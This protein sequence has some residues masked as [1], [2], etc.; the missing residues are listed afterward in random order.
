MDCHEEQLISIKNPFKAFKYAHKYKVWHTHISDK[1]SF[2][3]KNFMETY[4]SQFMRYKTIDTTLMDY[5]VLLYILDSLNLIKNT[6]IIHYSQLGICSLPKIYEGDHL[7]IVQAINSLPFSLGIANII[8]FRET[9]GPYKGKINYAFSENEN[10]KVSFSKDKPNFNTIKN[11][12]CDP[13]SGIIYI[14][15]GSNNF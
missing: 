13:K 3:W 12:F 8:L 11:K 14:L 9:E 4:Y 7:S 15:P 6:T 10:H 5:Y 1:N 2:V